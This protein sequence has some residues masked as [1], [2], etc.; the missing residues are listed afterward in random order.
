M[1]APTSDT[2]TAQ[3][4]LELR[5][6]LAKAAQEAFALQLYI[7]RSEITPDESAGKLAEILQPLQIEP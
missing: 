7:E 6:E 1:K 2:I 4:V 3:S 5:V